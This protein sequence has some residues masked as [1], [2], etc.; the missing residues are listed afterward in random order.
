MENI[1][2]Q[3]STVN[4]SQ[5]LECKVNE[6]TSDNVKEFRSMLASLL[7]GELTADIYV[8][9]SC[10]EY[11]DSSF[12]GAI[13]AVSKEMSERSGKLVLVSPRPQILALLEL[14]RLYKI[15]RIYQS[16]QEAFNLRAIA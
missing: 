10:I 8:D 2:F 4:N 6:A 11:M 15:C 5:V 14:T 16:R 7:E 3:L 1:M 9:L 13:V 12:L